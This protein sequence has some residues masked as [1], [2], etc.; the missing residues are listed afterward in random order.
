MW[1]PNGYDPEEMSV[2]KQLDSIYSH[3]IP[4][5]RFLI[6]Y[7]GSVG[8]ANALEYFV[9]AAHILRDDSVFFVVV[10]WVLTLKTVEGISF[11]KYIYKLDIGCYLCNLNMLLKLIYHSLMFCK[12]CSHL[13]HHF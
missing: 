9:E 2:P 13:H 10:D 12:T 8:L 11:V 5:D 3:L 4:Q 6:G 1:L 7:V